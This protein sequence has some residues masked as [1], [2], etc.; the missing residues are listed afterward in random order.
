MA[1]KLDRLGNWTVL[2]EKSHFQA[3]TLAAMCHVSLRHL[4]RYWRKS[5]HQSPQSWLR[6]LRLR[7][8]RPLLQTELTVKEIASHLGFK[9]SSHFCRE[10]KRCT[11]RTPNAFRAPDGALLAPT[12]LPP[13]RS[14]SGAISS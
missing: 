1:S 11:G 2:A 13:A 5:F 7:A 10:F 4:E 12:G 9:Q 14:S 8:A 6:E 3:K